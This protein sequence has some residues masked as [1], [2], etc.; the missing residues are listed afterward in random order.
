MF[1]LRLA[2]KD[3]VSS[4]GAKYQH[5]DSSVR[6]SGGLA[7]DGQKKKIKGKKTDELRLLFLYQRSYSWL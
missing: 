5:C 2:G 7:F 1:V 4:G 3:F 6:R